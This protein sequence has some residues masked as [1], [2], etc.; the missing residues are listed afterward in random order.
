MAENSDTER[1]GS[2]NRNA[3]PDR[4]FS[5]APQKRNLNRPII[6]PDHN[7]GFYHQRPLKRAPAEAL[8]PDFIKQNNGPETYRDLGQGLAS[9]PPFSRKLSRNNP[10]GTGFLEPVGDPDIVYSDNGEYFENSN[11]EPADDSEQQLQQC[12]RLQRLLL[13][14]LLIA[15]ATNV[16]LLLLK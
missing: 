7:K 6:E 10:A 2:G 8:A 1:K 16:L 3:N 11:Y 14:A 9:P 4:F 12:K 5:D 15:T 13:S